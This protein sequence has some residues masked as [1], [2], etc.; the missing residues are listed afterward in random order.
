MRSRSSVDRRE[1][2][3]GK[4]R[5]SDSSRPSPAPTRPSPRFHRQRPRPGLSHSPRLHRLHLKTVLMDAPIFQPGDESED[6][7]GAESQRQFLDRARNG[8][9]S[10]SPL[11]SPIRLDWRCGGARPDSFLSSG[12]SPAAI[13]GARLRANSQSPIPSTPPIFLL[14]LSSCSVLWPQSDRRL[15]LIQVVE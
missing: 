15:F 5:D 11:P 12:P 4:A 10:P 14:T 3:W 7:K 1:G 13:H 8:T 2:R 6:P 9:P